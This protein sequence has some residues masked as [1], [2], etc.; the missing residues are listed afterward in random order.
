MHS[1]VPCFVLFQ[2]DVTHSPVR[3]PLHHAVCIEQGHRDSR[4]LNRIVA[5]SLPYT[6]PNLRTVVLGEGGVL[7]PLLVPHSEKGGQVDE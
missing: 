7:S 4:I 5:I 3:I 1:V 6:D 2:C